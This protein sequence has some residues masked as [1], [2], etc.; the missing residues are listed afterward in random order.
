VSDQKAILI[1]DDEPSIREML[2]KILQREGFAVMTTG[3]VPDALALISQHRYDILISDLNIGHPADGFVVVSAMKRTY[4][5]ALTFIFTGYPAFET[6]LEALLQHVN[7]YLIKGTPVKELVDKI[8][9]CVATGQAPECPVKT[10]RVPDVVEEDKNWV[11]EQWL[12]RVKANAELMKVSLSDADRL[13]HVPALLDE[14]IA[15]ACGQPEGEGR[16]K[17][18]ER[19][20]TFRYHQGYSVPMLI[21]EAGLLQDAIAECIRRNFLVI[22]LSNLVSDMSTMWKTIMKELDQSTHS[23]M[24][25]YEWHSV[26]ADRESR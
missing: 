18:A 17:A 13:D 21:K 4:P 16:P 23:F 10:K 5:D 11:L 3:T 25:Q 12:Q 22:D 20:G 1:V 2:Q 19:H 14:A 26:Q 15:Q 6:A 7:D 8:H 24:T 9:T